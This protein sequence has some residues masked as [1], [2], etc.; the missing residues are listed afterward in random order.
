MKSIYLLNTQNWEKIKGYRDFAKFFSKKQTNYKYKD[1]IQKNNDYSRGI[2]PTALTLCT[3]Q[4]L[5]VE[6]RP[7]IGK[8]LYTGEKISIFSINNTI[9]VIF[10]STIT[11]G[12]LFNIDAALFRT[13][14]SLQINEEFENWKKKVRSTLTKNKNSTSV[15]FHSGFIKEYNNQKYNNIIANSIKKSKIKNPKVVF[16]GRSMG[17]AL[18]SISGLIFSTYHP[19]IQFSIVSISAPAICNSYMSLYFSFLLEKGNLLNFINLYNSDDIVTSIKTKTLGTLLASKLRHPFQYS[20]NNQVT[21]VKSN[22]TLI[23][24]GVA[25][26]DVY[27]KTRFL[28]QKYKLEDSPLVNHSIYHLSFNKKGV[29]F[30]FRPIPSKTN[31]DPQHQ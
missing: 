11:M 26:I 23:K 21:K 25:E 14:T 19:N 15:L 9:F 17:G 29:F 1:L 22:N 6:L 7:K 16:I 24:N 13:K 28:R 27:K 4:R 31:R 18:A 10:R 3:M 20:K 30:T 8:Q 2:L 12:E 5:S